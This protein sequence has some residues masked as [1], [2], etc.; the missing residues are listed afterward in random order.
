MTQNLFRTCK[1]NL[2]FCLRDWFSWFGHLDVLPRHIL[3]RQN[4]ATLCNLRILFLNWWSQSTK[5]RTREDR[6][7]LLPAVDAYGAEVG[8]STPLNG[9][10]GSVYQ[11][12]H[13]E[14]YGDSKNT[15]ITHFPSW[16]WQEI[17]MHFGKNQLD[18]SRTTSSSTHYNNLYLV[19]LYHKKKAVLHRLKPRCIVLCSDILRGHRLDINRLKW[20]W[21][22]YLTNREARIFPLA[23]WLQV[24]VPIKKVR[25]R[26]SFIPTSTIS[27]LVTWFKCKYCYLLQGVSHRFICPSQNDSFASCDLRQRQKD[28]NNQVLP[29]KRTL[30]W[31]K[32]WPLCWFLEDSSCLLIRTTATVPS[33]ATD[34]SRRSPSLL[35]HHFKNVQH[36]FIEGGRQNDQHSTGLLLLLVKV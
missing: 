33:S 35:Y 3:V 1:S 5:Q 18:L 24:L 6:S 14:F 36:R 29:N 25:R 17:W 34:W 11:P 31:T 28:C 23:G 10:S 2:I 12:P 16:P 20:R 15:E 19:T 21:L 8:T 9:S 30:P 26:P 32:R 22:V 7:F 27:L 4:S 13:R